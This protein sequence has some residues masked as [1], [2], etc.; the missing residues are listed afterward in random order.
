MDIMWSCLLMDVI[1]SLINFVNFSSVFLV[2]SVII[3]F[4]EWIFWFP[5]FFLPKFHSDCISHL[6]VWQI[7]YL[8]VKTDRKTCQVISAKFPLWDFL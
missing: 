5:F 8:L 1:I 4:N 2:G 3:M 7:S 6:S